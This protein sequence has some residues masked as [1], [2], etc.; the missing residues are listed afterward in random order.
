[1]KSNRISKIRGSNYIYQKGAGAKR[2]L[3]VLTKRRIEVKKRRM[4]RSHGAMKFAIG[5]EE[6]IAIHIVYR[7]RY[8]DTNTHLNNR[9][10][11]T[12]HE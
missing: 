7:I 6:N 11:D 5:Y 4:V 10:S 1:M 2:I 9:S 12:N 3:N 8:L